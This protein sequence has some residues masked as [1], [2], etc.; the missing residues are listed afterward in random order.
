[1]TLIRHFALS[2]EAASLP[3]ESLGIDPK[4]EG[5]LDGPDDPDDP[6]DSD[7]WVEHAPG[8]RERTAWVVQRA[9]DGVVE[10]WRAQHGK[11]IADLTVESPARAEVRISGRVLVPS[12]AAALQRAVRASLAAAGLEAEQVLFDV[13]VLTEESVASAWLRPIESWLDVLASPS[14]GAAL[15]TQWNRTEPPIR[16]LEA[17]D[18][19]LAIELADRTV[20]WVTEGS[21]EP[22]PD[23]HRPPSVAD[24]R[25]GWSGWADEAPAAAWGAALAPWINAPYRLGGRRQSG[26]DCSALTQRVF[27]EVLGMGLPRHSKDQVR[28]GRRVGR[29]E[30]VPGDLIYATHAERGVSHVAFVVTRSAEGAISVGH[31]G[32]D[33]GHVVDEPLVEFLDRYVFRAARRFPPGFEPP[34]DA[35]T[36]KPES[37]RTDRS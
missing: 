14:D 31:A 19:W 21:V 33:H 13:T 11:A 20:G 10:T 35:T 18:G 12:Q 3:A 27:A 5:R 4:L 24:W 34:T 9:V 8:K 29:F 36:P 15:T 16:A 7:E 30:L 25:S 37:A 28:F 32:L 23:A 1:M 22:A 26:V 6:D 2:H 17:V